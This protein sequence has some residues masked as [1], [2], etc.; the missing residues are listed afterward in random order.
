MLVLASASPRRKELISLISDDVIIHPSNA[1]ETIPDNISPDSVAEY[2][3]V[4]KATSV[5]ADFKNDT[6]IGCDTAVIIDDEILGK[7]AD[8]DDARRMLRLLSGKTHKVITGCAIIKNGK[9]LSFSETTYV[10]FYP[11]SDKEI[12]DYI[13]TLEPNDKAGAYGIQ[14][15]GSLLVKEI[16]GDYFNVVGLPVAKLNKMLKKI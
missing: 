14:G 11:L 12:E 8:Q 2:L 7:P 4:K 16:Q 6:V 13:L 1:D 5:A 9:S 3:A 10:T 15:F